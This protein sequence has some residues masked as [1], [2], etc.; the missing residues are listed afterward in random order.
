MAYYSLTQGRVIDEGRDCCSLESWGSECGDALCARHPKGFLVFLRP[1]EVFACDEYAEA[2]PYTVKSGLTTPFHRRRVECTVELCRQVVQATGPAP[3]IL[4]M[5]CGQGHITHELHK[6]YGTEIHGLDYSLSAIEYAWDHYPG[7]KFTVANAYESP[8]CDG[9]FD[10][11]VCNNL[12]EH[13]PDP[14]RLLAEIRRITT[15]TGFLI[16]STPSRY[17]LTNLVRVFLGRRVHLI[18]KHHVTEYSV[19]QVLEQLSYGGYEPLKAFSRFI[20][21]R[22]VWARLVKVALFLGI[23][24]LRSH[25]QLE[26]TVFYLAR[27]SDHDTP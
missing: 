6:A 12:W 5:G 19:G 11:V 22:A 18:S 3:R 14:L 23:T 13:V 7:V 15:P 17:R 24:V 1:E 9:H 8:Y 4:D 21:P 10:L 2:D 25:H 26:D 27:R 16:I 20:A